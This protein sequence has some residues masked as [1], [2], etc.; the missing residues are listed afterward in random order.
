[1][2]KNGTLVFTQGP[3]DFTFPRNGRPKLQTNEREFENKYL[4]K[5]AMFVAQKYYKH[6]RDD[7]V[8]NDSSF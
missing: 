2:E 1:M 7:S 8:E 4:A 3:E 5:L 6:E